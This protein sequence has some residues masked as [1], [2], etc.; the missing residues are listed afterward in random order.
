MTEAFW[1]QL[2][3]LL[4]AALIGLLVALMQS[5]CRPGEETTSAPAPTTATVVSPEPP[6]FQVVGPLEANAAVNLTSAA[7]FVLNARTKQVY[8]FETT[9]PGDR[10]SQGGWVDNESLLVMTPRGPYRAWLDGRTSS[11]PTSPT[12]TPGPEWTGV[13]P[14]GA[15][16]A[17]QEQVTYGEILVGP[18]SGRATFRLEA[19]IAPEW[20]STG[21]LLA[22]TGNFCTGFDLFLFDPASQK[23]RNLT[24]SLEPAALDFEWRPDG[25]AI[26]VEVTPFEEHRRMLDLIDVETGLIVTLVDADVDGDLVPLEWSPDGSRLLFAHGGGRGFCDSLG[27][28]DV[29]TPAPTTLETIG[30]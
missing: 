2:A 23:L 10:I 8:A 13:S 24:A 25:S 17:T 3:R 21:H 15:W 9:S 29:P 6:P 22:F 28:P 27:R 5:G 30:G 20:A 11:L 19:A 7:F 26:A 4:V 16:A 14:D 1:W 12:S 18:A